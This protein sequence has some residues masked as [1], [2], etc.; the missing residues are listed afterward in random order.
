[1]FLCLVGWPGPSCQGNQPGQ[2]GR[3]N[4]DGRTDRQDRKERERKRYRV[5]QGAS[6]RARET[7]RKTLAD[8]L[9]LRKEGRCC[10]ISAA[11]ND[12]NEAK[13]RHHG[14]DEEDKCQTASSGHSLFPLDG[15]ALVLCLA[16][17]CGFL[18]EGPDRVAGP[19]G[20]SWTRSRGSLSTRNSQAGEEASRV[21]C[22]VLIL[23]KAEE[24]LARTCQAG[25]SSHGEETTF[26]L[27]FDASKCKIGNLNLETFFWEPAKTR[28][29]Q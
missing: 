22:L 20:R 15:K 28:P 21:F 13:G 24:T 9:D 4:G 25:S 19:K 5:R 11:D 8:S 16:L 27:S 18:S 1:M 17:K 6:E 2:T 23:A 14:H 29:D 7:R 3:T 12:D 26:E 10:S